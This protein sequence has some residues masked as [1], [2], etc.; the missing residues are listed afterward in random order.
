M[1]QTVCP[2]AM[3]PFP[4]AQAY[5]P[6]A[7]AYQPGMP[8]FAPPAAPG[9]PAIG[10][11]N[12]LEHILE[13]V[14][15]L[16]AAGMQ[17]EADHL[18]HECD[19]RLRSAIANLRI[20][21][22]QWVHK[23]ETSVDQ[24]EPSAQQAACDPPQALATA[25]KHDPKRVA[26]HVQMLEFNRTKMGNLG[27]D[28]AASDGGSLPVAHVGMAGEL[29]RSGAFAKFVEA[30]KREG[31][32][33]VLSSPSVITASGR[34]ASVFVG[35]EIPQFASGANPSVEF[36]KIGTEIDVVPFITGEDKVRLEIRGRYRT[37]DQQATIQA[38]Q[39]AG[40]I[41]PTIKTHAIDTATELA[42]GHVLVLGGT[43]EKHVVSKT[44]E[45]PF[46]SSIADVIQSVV[47]AMTDNEQLA[48]AV[49]GIIPCT[50]VVEQ[51]EEEIEQLMLVQPEIV[52]SQEA[53][54]KTEIQAGD[55]RPQTIDHWMSQ[56]RVIPP[57]WHPVRPTAAE[58]PAPEECE[59]EQL[60]PKFTVPPP[61]SG[62]S[63]PTGLVRPP[64]IPPATI[65]WSR[66]GDLVPSA[67]EIHFEQLP[68]TRKIFD[69]GEF[70]GMWQAPPSQPT[71]YI[72]GGVKIGR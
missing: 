36:S 14:H 13:A 29:V 66:A 41:Y 65:Y 59:S 44:Q 71:E 2:A 60:A 50:R 8:S 7:I 27:F 19:Q 1:S 22:S 57:Q 26:I 9:S 11:A 4:P 67:L 40:T 12:R 68:E 69:P 5:L 20:A 35:S 24:H 34:P 49:C 48:D 28:F 61:E 32:V 15:H 43:T 62:P 38:Y 16:E 18:R 51:H 70:F 10:E 58:S 64:C 17:A 3:P 53:T 45:I 21:E 6:A 47:M 23:H 46:T 33:R 54:P 39:A 31:I 56:P 42:S 37:I 63:Q 30:L 72:F 55:Q 25:Q 52:D